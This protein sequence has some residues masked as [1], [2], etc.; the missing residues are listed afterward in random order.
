MQIKNI[1]ISVLILCSILMTTAKVHSQSP[2]TRYHTETEA[3][4]IHLRRASS[5]PITANRV[6]ISVE[7]GRRIIRANGIADHN[8]GQFPGSGNPN[9]IREQ[10]LQYSLPL[11]P[12]RNEV[13]RF[14]SLGIFG[15]GVNGVLFD[16][17]AA[18]W[19]QGDRGSKWQYDPLGGALALGLDMHHAHVQR[20]GTYHYHGLPTGLLLNVGISVG[21]HSPLIGW[22][23]DGFPIYALYG[24]MGAAVK[25]MKPSYRLKKG[26]RSGTNAPGGAYDGAFIAD[27]EY[28]PGLGDLDACNGALTISKEF[29][30]GT[31][32]YFLTSAFPVVPR[33]FMGT[34]V[35]SGPISNSAGSS[36]N[37]GHPDLKGAARRLGVDVQELRRALGTPPP[38]LKN[39]ARKLGVS[40]DA[41]MRALHPQ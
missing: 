19:Y 26:I 12:A 32:A 14:Y 22:A 28:M 30:N 2:P 40:E 21:K 25:E 29:P 20:N 10:N 6:L 33:C 38:N 17:Q 37:R 23:M 9:T 1:G 41:L 4:E 3:G 5:E 18:E 13:P 35:V 27:W 36:A 34:P 8:T 16:P 7:K 11:S 24:K 39:A 31:Y 15:I